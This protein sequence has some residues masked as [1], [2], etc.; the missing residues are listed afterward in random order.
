V[1][2][3]VHCVV[4]P[5]PTT[6]SLGCWKCASHHTH[7][8][9]SQMS[10]LKFQGSDLNTQKHTCCTL[11]VPQVRSSHFTRDLK[12]RGHHTEARLPL[13]FKCHK[14]AVPHSQECFT[15]MPTFEL[16]PRCKTGPPKNDC[17]MLCTWRASI[18]QDSTCFNL[19]FDRFVFQFRRGTGPPP[20]HFSRDPNNHIDFEHENTG[21]HECQHVQDDVER[22][23]NRAELDGE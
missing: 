5:P 23:S 15:V 14:R 21:G 17:G 3:Y 4:T 11:Q 18:L 9:V 10:L 8:C 22:N 2:E 19:S 6:P 16:N 20:A 12:K 1:E 13:L 7:P